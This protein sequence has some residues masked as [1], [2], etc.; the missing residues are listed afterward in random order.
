MNEI[1][2][3]IFE[4]PKDDKIK[5]SENGSPKRNNIIIKFGSDNLEFL[6]DIFNFLEKIYL[7]QLAIITNAII[8][9]INDN[10]YLTLIKEKDNENLSKSIFTYIWERECYFNQ[11]GNL[12]NEYSPKTFLPLNDLPCSSLNIML[13]GMSRSG[14]ST[15]INV[16]SNK[17][18][19]LETPELES[20]TNEI[21]E[22]VIYRRANS[23]DIVKFKFIDTPGLT[24]IPKDQKYSITNVIDTISKKL[25]EFE[26]TNDSIH[27]IYFLM[28]GLPNLEN[29]KS[30]F[31]FLNDL[32]C[33][34]VKKKIFLKFLF[35]LYLIEIQV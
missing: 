30:F 20:V 21:N 23:K 1:I 2:Y 31:K 4:V 16:L 3:N 27:I 11:R 32:N 12:I 8:N 22:Y 33:E 9:G 35:Y 6:L 19:S 7:P 29:L 24:F 28:S 18:V 17:L 10:R 34:R 13:T 25:K 15:L 26:D 5:K 14:K